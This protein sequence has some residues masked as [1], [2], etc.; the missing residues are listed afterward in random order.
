[1]QCGHRMLLADVQDGRVR[2]ELQAGR[3]PCTLSSECCSQN[4]LG[5]ICIPSMCQSQGSPCTY[6]N[7]C[8]NKKCEMGA[9][10]NCKPGASQC[11]SPSECC[12]Q[13]CVGGICLP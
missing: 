7:E 11:M 6:N 3:G 12:S 2:H 4:C 1:M 10:A 8:C 9:C 13:Q 5:G